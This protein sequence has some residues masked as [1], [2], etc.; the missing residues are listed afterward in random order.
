MTDQEH[1]PTTFEL[2][3][4]SHPFGL[5]DQFRDALLRRFEPRISEQT[6]RNLERGVYEPDETRRDIINEVAIEIYNENIY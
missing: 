3:V 2:F 4:K 5:R 6:Y 1:Q